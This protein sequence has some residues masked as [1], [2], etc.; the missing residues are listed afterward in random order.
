MIP[1]FAEADMD[2]LLSERVRVFAGDDA[3]LEQGEASQCHSNSARLYRQ[4]RGEIATGYA[5]SKD[6]YWRQHSWVVAADGHVIET[7]T[8]RQRYVGVVLDSAAADSFAA[9]QLDSED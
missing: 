5:L 1:T 9:V 7:T 4:G 2:A 3:E 8:L 6:G